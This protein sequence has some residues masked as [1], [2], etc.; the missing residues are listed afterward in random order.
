M[1]QIK[2]A[3]PTAAGLPTFASAAHGGRRAVLVKR[4]GVWQDRS[5][6]EVA[7]EI[8]R[9]ARGFIAHGSSPAIVSASWR[10]A[11]GVVGGF[12]RAL[13]RGRRGR[14]DLPSNSPEECEW[15]AGN[16]GRLR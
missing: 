2:L 15:V 5:Y 4:D 16:S 7:E 10:H 14:A 9:L 1:A 8:E 11:S 13:E 3:P 6:A 12:V